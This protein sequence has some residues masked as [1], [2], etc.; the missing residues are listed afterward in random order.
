MSKGLLFWI[1]MIA[2]LLFGL[3]AFWPSS[4][5][6]YRPLGFNAMLFILLGLL[7]WQSFGQPVK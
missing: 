2:W 5:G 3:W 1:I 7:G 6:T 4:G